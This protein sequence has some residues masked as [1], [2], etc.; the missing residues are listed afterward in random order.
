[1]RPAS[2]AVVLGA[3]IVTASPLP[4]GEEI[5]EG[6]TEAKTELDES[7]PILGRTSTSGNCFA[8]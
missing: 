5:V 1:M 4:T 7:C 3:V 2:P 6:I 8:V